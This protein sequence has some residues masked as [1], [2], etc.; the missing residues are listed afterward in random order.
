MVLLSGK[1]PTRAG[2]GYEAKCIRYMPLL[3]IEDSFMVPPV[4]R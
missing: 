3:T 2:P 4:Q 1:P